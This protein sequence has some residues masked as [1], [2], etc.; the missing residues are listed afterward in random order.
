MVLTRDA[1]PALSDDGCLRTRPARATS[2][3]GFPLV[4]A[5]EVRAAGSSMDEARR[6]LSR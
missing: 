5:S 6:I 1:G 4:S 3:T 2:G